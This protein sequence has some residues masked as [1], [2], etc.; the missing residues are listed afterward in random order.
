MTIKKEVLALGLLLTVVFLFGILANFAGSYVTAVTRSQLY[1]NLV[2]ASLFIVLFLLVFWK[3]GLFREGKNSLLRNSAY[4]L[5]LPAVFY[6]LFRCYFKIPFVFCSACPNKC[7]FGEIRKS[8]V[9]LALLINLDAGHWCH[10]LCPVGRIQDTQVRVGK[11]RR[12]WRA[13]S[14]LKYIA[15]AFIVISVVAGISYKVNTS[16]S[17]FVGFFYDRAY[18]LPLLAFA[19]AMLFFLVSFVIPRFWCNYLCPI[20]TIGEAG[21]WLEQKMK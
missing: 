13:V 3:Q 21:V 17:D 4:L 19:A 15:L 6:P 2:R 18:A 7:V 12:L 9:P 1:V 8:G 10:H 5:F 11:K 14:L 16:A 20:G